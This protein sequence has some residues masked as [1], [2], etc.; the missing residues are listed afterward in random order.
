MPDLF[1]TDVLF[2]RHK[3]EINAKL[4][5]P[6]TSLVGLGSAV[7][8]CASV[9]PTVPLKL[10]FFNIFQHHLATLRGTEISTV[11][12]SLGLSKISSVPCWQPDRNIQRLLR[13]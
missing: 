3:R 1:Q 4:S 5:N 9:P 7:D 6:R 12:N 10:V 8:D 13:V 2:A 11:S